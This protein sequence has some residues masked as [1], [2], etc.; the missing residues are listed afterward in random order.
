METPDLYRSRIGDI[1][2]KYEGDDGE[3]TRLRREDWTA[4]KYWELGGDRVEIPKLSPHFEQFR[5]RNCSQAPISRCA[6]GSETRR[7]FIVGHER[8]SGIFSA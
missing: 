2:H 6:S 5:D 8:S 7:S 3:R 1:G 4:W